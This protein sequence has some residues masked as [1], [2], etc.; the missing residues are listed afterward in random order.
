MNNQFLVDK[1][2]D[3][4]ITQEKV[5][6]LAGI[7]R[8]YYSKIEN[9]TTPSVRVAK[10]LAEVLQIEWILF[11]EGNGVKNAQNKKSK[12]DSARMEVG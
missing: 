7:E 8:S 12:L 11:F 1:R 5:A 4:G 9:G 6:E 3:L 10:R 2:N